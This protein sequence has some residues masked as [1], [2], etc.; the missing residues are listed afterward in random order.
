MPVFAVVP[1]REEFLEGLHELTDIVHSS[2]KTCT[3]GLVTG[4]LSGRLPCLPFSLYD[5]GALNPV[6]YGYAPQDFL[7]IQFLRFWDAHE[8]V[9]VVVHDCVGAEFNARELKRSIEK[10]DEMRL[11]PVGLKEKFLVRHPCDKMVP[12]RSRQFD[13]FYACHWAVLSSWLW[14]TQPVYPIIV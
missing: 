14:L 11:L 2:Q 13:S 12:G 8:Q 9:D 10:V 6:Q 7:I 5:L 4:F 3:I 1:H